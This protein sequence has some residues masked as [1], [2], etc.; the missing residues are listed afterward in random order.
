MKTRFVPWGGTP[1]HVMQAPFHA[2]VSL[3]VI[4]EAGGSGGIHGGFPNFQ[5]KLEIHTN[6]MKHVCLG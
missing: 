3:G 2:D 6:H 5:G 4:A 1:P